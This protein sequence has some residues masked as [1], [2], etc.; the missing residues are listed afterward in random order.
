MATIMKNNCILHFVQNGTQIIFA[1]L[2]EQG[3]V[4]VYQIKRVN[5]A[6]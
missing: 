2:L 6:A 5:L 3:L 4:S 1:K